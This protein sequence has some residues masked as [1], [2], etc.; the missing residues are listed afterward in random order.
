M[1]FLILIPGEKNLLGQTILYFGAIYLL[2]HFIISGKT[3][4]QI[5]MSWAL[6]KSTAINRNKISD[7]MKRT[8]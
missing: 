3:Y 4:R 7:L 2:L 6:F 1:E 5:T 8:F